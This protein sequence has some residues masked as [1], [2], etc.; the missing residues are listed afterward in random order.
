MVFEPNSESHFSAEGSLHQD[1]SV[2]SWGFPVFY[3][4]NIIITVCKGFLNFLCQYEVRCCFRE[5][6]GTRPS[7]IIVAFYCLVGWQLLWWMGRIGCMGWNGCKDRFDRVTLGVKWMAVLVQHYP[8]STCGSASIRR[9]R[10][11]ICKA[12]NTNQC[13]LD[14]CIKVSSLCKNF[15]I[16]I[17]SLIV[18]KIVHSSENTCFAPFTHL[19]NLSRTRA[20]SWLSINQECTKNDH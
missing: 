6:Y 11:R 9:P 13:N 10:R 3:S 17:T 19:A 8:M 18:W 5:G 4:A 14:K 2:R 15:T 7:W 20:I 12:S 1:I 16:L